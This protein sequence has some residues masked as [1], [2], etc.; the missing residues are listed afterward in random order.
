MR[1]TSELG[2]LVGGVGGVALLPQ[3]LGGPQEHAGALLPA[4]DVGPLVHEQREVAV[5]VD[6]AGE[7]VADDGLAGRADDVG[8]V[9]LFAAGVGDDR[10]LGREALDVLGLLGDEDSAG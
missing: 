3:E 10:E 6:P 7:E 1:A 8:L 2:L 9:E 5:A 4:H